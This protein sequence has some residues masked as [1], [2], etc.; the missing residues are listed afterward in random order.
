MNGKMFMPSVCTILKYSAICG[1]CVPIAWTL[2]TMERSP[3]NGSWYNVHH[4]GDNV[5]EWSY[6]PAKGTRRTNFSFSAGKDIDHVQQTQI[7][8]D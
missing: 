3:I 6:Y 2:T 5:I 7:Y 1:V 8:I 4:I